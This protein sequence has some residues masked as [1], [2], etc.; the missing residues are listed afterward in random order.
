MTVQIAKRRFTVAE[1]CAMGLAGILSEDDRVELIDGEIVEMSLIGGRHSAC[2]DRLNCLSVTALADTA[3]VRIQD[4][5]RLNDRSEPEPDRV[6]A[7]RR[8]SMSENSTVY[9]GTV[10]TF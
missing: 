9:A 2:V 3:I 7:V 1:Y 4:P 5:V 6:A 10:L 8:R